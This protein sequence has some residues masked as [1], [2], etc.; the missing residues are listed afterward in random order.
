RRIG[1]TLQLI[2]QEAVDL[3]GADVVLVRKLNTLPLSWTVQ[4][5]LQAVAIAALTM[6]PQLRPSLIDADMQAAIVL[7]TGT[8]TAAT[9][10]PLYVVAR[11]MVAHAIETVP[12]QVADEAMRDA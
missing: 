5:A 6:I 3:P 12:W 11:A 9:S 7:L 4:L 1:P 8:V 10:L 2:E